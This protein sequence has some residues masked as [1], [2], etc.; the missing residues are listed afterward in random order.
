MTFGLDQVLFT[1]MNRLTLVFN[2]TIDQDVLANT[3]PTNYVISGDVRVVGNFS[4]IG[5]TV[6]FEISLAE[7]GK[8]YDITL[9]NLV[10][11]EGDTLMNERQSFFFGIGAITPML[12]NKVV[13]WG[14]LYAIFDPAL[15]GPIVAVTNPSFE[16]GSSRGQSVVASYNEMLAQIPT[17]GTYNVST[18]T[19]PF[20]TRESHFL[21]VTD[22]NIEVGMYVNDV[23]LGSAMTNFEGWVGFSPIL[24]PGDVNLRFVRSTSSTPFN[25]ALVNSKF[26][27]WQGAIADIL[28]SIDRD[29][30]RVK[31]SRSI[32]RVNSDDVDLNFGQFYKTPRVDS[33]SL[34]VY[35][36]VLIEIIQA[37]RYWSA[38]PEGLTNVVAA[39]TQVRPLLKWFRRDG[40]RWVLAWQHFLNREMT[41]RPR[42]ATSTIPSANIAA[43]SVSDS[44]DVGTA[45]IF[46]DPVGGTMQYQSVGDAFGDPVPVSGAGTY[47]LTS[48]NGV[49]TIVVEVSSPTPVVAITI[50]VTVTGLPTPEHTRIVN[51]THKIVS[52][53]LMQRSGL[54]IELTATSA[55]PSIELQADP[56]FYEHLGEYFVASFWVKQDT[57]ADRDFVVEVSEDGG[58]TWTTGATKTVPDGDYTRVDHAQS[59]GDFTTT[60]IRARLRALDMVSG[61]SFLVEK[62]ALHSPQTGALY[63]GRNTI[64]RTRRRRFFG[65]ELLLFFRE[66]LDLQAYITLGLQPALGWGLDPWST[67][68][69]GSPSFGF[70][71]PVLESPTSTA[72]V[73]LL[74]YIVPTHVEIVTFQ[75]SV[76]AQ[77]NSGVANVKGVVYESD[78]RAG[79][80]E[81][82]TVVPRVPDVFSHLVPSTTTRRTEVVTF[83]GLGVATL[84]QASMQDADASR[85]TRNGEPIPNSLWSY[86]DSTHIQV[87]VGE[88]DAAKTFQFT[89]TVVIS[90]ESD[91]IDLGPN[92]DLFNWYADWYEYNRARLDG[93][94][95]RQLES[96]Q[97]SPNSLLG[98]LGDRAD[99]DS[100]DSILSQNNGSST[101]PVST[102]SWRFIDPATI[103]IDA[104]VFDP[105]FIYSLEYTAKSLIKVPVCTSTVEVQ[106]STDGMTFSSWV[107]IPHDAPFGNKYR[108]WKFR[109]AVFNVNDV[110]DFKLRSL[111]LK[112]DPLD[113]ATIRDLV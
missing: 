35:R 21:L 59:L 29:I 72:R 17:G 110:R 11:S 102:T 37:F 93:V 99:T 7:E 24:P 81:N 96:V 26:M 61:D 50:P 106:Y 23:F 30:T 88:L 95:Q 80:M 2:Q 36:E 97:F 16:L 9:N 68:P 89:Y 28:G 56:T 65:Y 74:N 6:S 52:G 19:I 69:Y 90:F 108:Y 91:V 75:D 51:A 87:N 105:T 76:L 14:E 22:P 60:D 104:D 83:D 49:D 92:W 8:V 107:T 1:T 82:F 55:T 77:D 47:T 94:S 38:T 15:V 84:S 57:G 67:S 112:G 12:V 43:V 70:L 103:K 18:V 79:T 27:T 3:D 58:T 66:P 44:N 62:A 46:Y 20:H 64:P 4:I 42:V 40:P 111:V 32:E 33:Y 71:R 25:A 63:L 98:T 41:K 85:L 39:F 34:D 100:S 53:A 113:R 48:D 45:N 73:G 78:W 10:S 5:S 101:T 86:V 109:I 31:D 13:R 54:V